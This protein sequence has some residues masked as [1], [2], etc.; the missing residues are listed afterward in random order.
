MYDIESLRREEFPA[1]ASLTYLNHAG[2][3][4]LPQRTKREVQSAI[5]RLSEDPNAFFG[6]YALPAF[7]SLQESLASFIN[8]KSPSEIVY[9]TT[10]SAALNAVAQAIDWRPGDNILFCDQEFP[11]NAYPWMSLSRDGVESRR[12]PSENGG[13]TLRQVETHA[14]DRTRAVTVSA[15]QFFSGHRAD[16]VAIGRFC[17]ERNILFI[18][19]AIQAI[20]HMVFDVQAMNID[21]LATGG[22]KSLLALPGAGFIYVRDGVSSKMNPRLIHGNSTVDYLHWLDYDL[23]PQPGAARLSSGTTNVPGV[24]S[25]G[26]SLTLLNDLGPANIDKHTTAL[27]HYAIDNLT[28]EGYEVVTSKDT[29]GPIATFRSPFDSETTDRLIQFLSDRQVVVCKHLDAGTSAYMRASVHCYNTTADIDRLLE[30][31]RGFVS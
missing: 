14:D 1:S 31:L 6:K 5:E 15:I 21:I 3:S 18:V 17:R 23:T 20:G 7:V 9:S 8:A 2:I 13:L 24:L 11:S 29:S 16:L 12:V 4:P 22:M 26:A 30:E 27:I 25:I 19:D 28:N 10:T